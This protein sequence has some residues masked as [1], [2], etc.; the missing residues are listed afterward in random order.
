MR[1]PVGFA[2]LQGLLA[3]IGVG[4]LRAAGLLGTGMRP[5]VLGLGPAWLLGTT[6]VGLSLVLLLVLGVPFTLTTMGILSATL[7]GVAFALAWH[8]G[9]RTER[10][11]DTRAAPPRT[12]WLTRIA[13]T[14]AAGYVGFGAYAV[15]R[16]PTQADDARIWS[17]KGL[18]LTYYD[19]LRPEIFLNS[20]TVVSHHVYPLLLPALEAALGRAMGQPELRLFHT[21]LW[22]L[23]IASIWTAAYLIWWRRERPAREQAGVALLALVALTPEVVSNISTGHVD[24]TGAVLLATGAVALGLWIDGAGDGHLWLAAILL[25]AAANA[26]DEDMVG[27]VIVL[28][29][30]GAVLVTRSHR[31]RLRAWLGAAGVCALLVLPWRIWTAA[32]HLRDAVTPP[33]PR[34]L[35]PAFLLDR[36]PELRRTANALLSHTLSEW[37]WAAAIFVTLCA[38]SLATGTSRR[39]TAFYLISLAAIVAVFLWLYGTTPVSLSLIIPRSLS[40][41]VDVFMVLAA[42]ASAHLVTKLTPGLRRD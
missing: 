34:A 25:G 8:R 27:A 39:L 37:G 28:L 9:V 35:T 38:V 7:A 29:A 16:A 15:A 6:L 33:L 19:S 36:A 21:E 17:L 5:T 26:K 30:A 3:L 23:L 41:T 4:S 13:V 11:I 42:F 1:G 12:L 10:L 22:L 32:H 14:A 20:A 40:R 18:A 2:M 31:A 24:A